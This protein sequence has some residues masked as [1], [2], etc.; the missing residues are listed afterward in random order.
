MSLPNHAADAALTASVASLAVMLGWDDQYACDVRQGA[1]EAMGGGVHPLD[2]V[3]LLANA[4]RRGRL[5]AAN[6]ARARAGEPVPQ[7]SLFD[8]GLTLDKP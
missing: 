1:E 3:P 8:D 4:L 5:A 6:A 7:A 2:D